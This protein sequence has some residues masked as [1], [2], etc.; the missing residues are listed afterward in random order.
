MKRPRQRERRMLS[1]TERRAVAARARYV[2]SGEHKAGGWWG[3][4]PKARQLPGGRVGRRGKQ[5]PT[6]CPLTSNQD[7]ER[8]TSWVRQAIIEGQY[9]FQE[10]DG[11]FPKKIWYEADGRIWFGYC[12]NKES[13][14]YKGWPIDE[15]ERRAVF[16]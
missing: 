16:G 2:G 13:G 12:L 9:R 6:V 3:G 8:A 14:E 1:P 10:S 4:L 7:R 5:T 11:D 15:G